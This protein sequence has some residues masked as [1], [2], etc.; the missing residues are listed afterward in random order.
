[1]E[2]QCSL[3]IDLDGRKVFFHLAGSVNQI[4][5][6]TYVASRTLGYDDKTNNS[7]L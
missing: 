7:A 5:R 1:M 3:N 6:E 4:N 2:E